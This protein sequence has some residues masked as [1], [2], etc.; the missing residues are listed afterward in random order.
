[1]STLGTG[2]VW[3]MRLYITVILLHVIDAIV[4]NIKVSII[5]NQCDYLLAP[6]LLSLPFHVNITVQFWFNVVFRQ[7]V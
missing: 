3:Y 6:S 5:L 1:M 4:C 2:M 7:Q